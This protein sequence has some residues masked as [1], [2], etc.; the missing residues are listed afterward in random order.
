MSPRSP[1]A[2]DVRTLWSAVTC[3]L[4]LVACCAAAA[5]YEGHRADVLEK[6]GA[7][8]Q[9]PEHLFHFAPESGVGRLRPVE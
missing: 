7:A 4:F 5:L 9:T 1:E 8:C 6:R 2:Q 3:L